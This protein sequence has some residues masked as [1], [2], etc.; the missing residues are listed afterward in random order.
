MASS[1]WYTASELPKKFFSILASKA[2]QT[3]LHAAE[4]DDSTQEES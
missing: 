1:K 3:S 4:I 2:K